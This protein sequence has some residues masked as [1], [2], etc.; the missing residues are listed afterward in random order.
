MRARSSTEIA[1]RLRQ[2]IAAMDAAHVAQ[3]DAAYRAA[4]SRAFSLALALTEARTF[5]EVV[6]RLNR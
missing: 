6:E 3:D 2:T 4:S 1:T 5:S